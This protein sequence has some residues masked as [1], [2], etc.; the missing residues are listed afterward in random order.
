MIGVRWIDINKG[1][2]E[3]PDYRSRLAAKDFKREDR[4]DLFVA[5]PP[6]EA[7]KMRLSIVASNPGM[8]IMRNHVKITY[9]HAPVRRP[10]YVELPKEDRLDGEEDLA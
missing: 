5:T 9:F 4:P 10:V 7:L 1:D 8:H 6:L 3:N 2:G